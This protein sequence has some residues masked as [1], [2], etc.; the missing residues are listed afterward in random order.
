MVGSRSKADGKTTFTCDL[1]ERFSAKANVVAVKISTIDSLNANHHP[2]VTGSG[3]DNASNG[4]YCITE[5]RY[6]GAHTDTDRMARAGAAKVIWL[7]ALSSRLEE[8]ISELVSL[9]GDETIS[10][11]ESNRARNAIEPG[12]FVMIRGEKE[13]PWKPSAK[14]VLLHADRTIVSN[15]NEFDFDP[16]DIQLV[17]RRWAVKLQATAIIL[18]G[19]NSSRMG[20]DKTMLPVCDR[21]MVEHVY[22]QL[23]P[24]FKQIIVSTN[25]I[26]RH[27]FLGAKVVEDEASGKGPLM[28]IASSLK[29]SAHDVNF[30]IACDIPEIDTGLI[31][32]MLRQVG[33]Y[34]AVA[35]AIAPMRYEPLF[36]VYRKSSLPIIEQTLESGNNRVIDALS[37]CRVKYIDLSGRQL[38]NVNTIGDYHR[39]IKEKIDAGT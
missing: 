9:L 25:N 33:D 38:T 13:I 20:Q 5:E 27:S 24:Y 15:G 16:N 23:R 3:S 30:V 31:R 4:S 36:A 19:G 18:A 2:D 39:F 1:I 14:E 11:C 7:Q 28:G 22:E 8:G 37:H 32:A 12:A 17:N 35:P 21:P 10:I 29:A 26:T 34:D 6:T